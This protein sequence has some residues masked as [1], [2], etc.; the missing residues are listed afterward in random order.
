MGTNPLSTFK[1]EGR[2]NV[3]PAFEAWLRAYRTRLETTLQTPEARDSVSG[4]KRD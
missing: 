3:S 4:E 1:A 2:E